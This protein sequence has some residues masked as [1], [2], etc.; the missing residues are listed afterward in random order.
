MYQGTIK[1]WDRGTG[2]G[3]IKPDV[4]GRDVALYSDHINDPEDRAKLSAGQ[5]VEF[6]FQQGA[7]TVEAGN[8]RLLSA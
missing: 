8:V 6:E 3:F 4:G 1:S 2:R 7:R 5:R